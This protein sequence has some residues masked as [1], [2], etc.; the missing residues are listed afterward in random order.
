MVHLVLIIKVGAAFS[1]SWTAMLLLVLNHDILLVCD[2]QLTSA[3]TRFLCPGW[4][5]QMDSDVTSTVIVMV[6]VVYCCHL[7]Q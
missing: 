4:K 7:H 6:T 1:R 3:G 5:P 2:L